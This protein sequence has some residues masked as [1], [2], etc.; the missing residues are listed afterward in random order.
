MSSASAISG[1]PLT[2]APLNPRISINS[3]SARFSP[4]AD[5]AQ[6]KNRDI[7]IGI[8]SKSYEVP[9]PIPGAR[10][11]DPYRPQK[12]VDSWPPNF[13][14]S[15]FNLLKPMNPSV[16]FD[17]AKIKE[18]V[19]KERQRV[20]LKKQQAKDE[21][22]KRLFGTVKKTGGGAAALL[23]ANPLAKPGGAGGAGGA[24]AA[25]G[26]LSSVD[27]HAKQ[28][29][30]HHDVEAYKAKVENML[31]M[32]LLIRLVRYETFS[33]TLSYWYVFFFCVFVCVCVWARFE[34]WRVEFLFCLLYRSESSDDNFWFD[35][36]W[37]G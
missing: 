4:Y 24:G 2:T 26:L 27:P 31:L 25:G 10:H 18:Y 28:R 14:A 32:G 20:E 13:N 30:E 19:R 21:Q 3:S 12:D 7:E 23:P 1:K 5:L 36:I 9:R 6:L 8:K 29:Q 33:D 17:D 11:S 34:F 35:L 15:P 16:A 37:V 22:M